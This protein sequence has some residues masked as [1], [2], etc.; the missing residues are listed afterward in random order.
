MIE[1]EFRDTPLTYKGIKGSVVEKGEKSFFV[2]HLL[3]Y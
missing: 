2:I 1:N 3:I